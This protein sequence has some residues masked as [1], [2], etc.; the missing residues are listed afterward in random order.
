MLPGMQW[1]VHVFLIWYLIFSCMHHTFSPN[2]SSEVQKRQGLKVRQTWYRCQARD[3]EVLYGEVTDLSQENS[4]W[5]TN[6]ISS[7]LQG[8]ARLS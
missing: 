3:R 6:R 7:A 8:S 5:K 1:H 4:E 2:T